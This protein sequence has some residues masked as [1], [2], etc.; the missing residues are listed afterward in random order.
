MARSPCARVLACLALLLL[1]AC[2]DYDRARN[3]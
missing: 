2:S 1:T 3:A